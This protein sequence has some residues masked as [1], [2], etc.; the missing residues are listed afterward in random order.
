M[1]IDG[2]VVPSRCDPYSLYVQLSR[3][4]SLDSMILVS[5]ARGIDFIGNR[6]PEDMVIG[7]RQLEKLSDE[8]VREAET[9]DW[10][11]VLLEVLTKQNINGPI[12]RRKTACSLYLRGADGYI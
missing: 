7:E 10:N 4:E 1:R 5:K 3:C 11:D 6:V 12:D 9:W 2:E 8:T